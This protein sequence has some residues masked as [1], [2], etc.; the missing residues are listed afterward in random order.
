MLAVIIAI[1]LAAS[2]TEKVR[3]FLKIPHLHTIS[4][5]AIFAQKTR[6]ILRPSLTQSIRRKSVTQRSI[7]NSFQA[8]HRQVFAR[9][10]FDKWMQFIDVLMQ[11]CLMEIKDN[12]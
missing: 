3:R 8:M 6:G 12:D 4:L 7:K 1:K 2:A 11:I 5:I 9:L 10:F